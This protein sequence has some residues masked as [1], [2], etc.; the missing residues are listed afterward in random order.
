L[1]KIILNTKAIVGVVLIVEAESGGKSAKE[2]LIE[3]SEKIL[4]FLN[5]NLKKCDIDKRKYHEA[6]SCDIAKHI[7]IDKCSLNRNNSLL[8][9]SDLLKTIFSS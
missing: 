8:S 9:F 1:L 2:Y 5:K 7:E 6:N 4:H 3:Y